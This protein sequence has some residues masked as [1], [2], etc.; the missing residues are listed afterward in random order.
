MKIIALAYN[1]KGLGKDTSKQPFFFFKNPDS[2]IGDGDIIK[3]PRRQHVWPEVELALRVAQDNRFDGIAIANDI[4]IMNHDDRDV[5]LAYSKGLDTFLP[6]GEWVHTFDLDWVIRRCKMYLT[7]N[8]TRV[9]TGSLSE[10]LWKP[11]QAFD[12]ISKYLTFHPGDILLM[13]TCYH[14]HYPLRDGDKIYMEIEDYEL[15]GGFRV[16]SLT[17]K[18]VEV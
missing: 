17:N 14:N 4:T 12:R 5:H 13:G 16:G 7:V 3:I 15:E 1:F 18:V 9:Q 10:M 11:L 6:M 8:D 2:I